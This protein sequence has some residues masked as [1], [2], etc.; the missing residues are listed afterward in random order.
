MRT[1]QEVYRD[2]DKVTFVVTWGINDGF[3]WSDLPAPMAMVVADGELFEETDI[4]GVTEADYLVSGA[5]Y[6]RRP[7]LRRRTVNLG[8]SGAVSIHTYSPAI[9]PG[10]GIEIG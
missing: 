10:E 7:P 1:W 4:D 8:P 6:T 9:W 2:A 5:T 3:D